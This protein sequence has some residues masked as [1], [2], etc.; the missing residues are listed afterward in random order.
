MMFTTGLIAGLDRY[1]YRTRFCYETA[2]EAERALAEWNGE[3]WPP[4]YWVKQKPQDVAN[5]LRTAKS[6]P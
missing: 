4:G 1:G 6:I 3:G 5:P 2:P